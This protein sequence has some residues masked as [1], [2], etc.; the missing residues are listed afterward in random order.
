[1]DYFWS[2]YDTAV[3]LT[4]NMLNAAGTL[5]CVSGGVGFSISYL[6]ANTLNVDY[7]GE[8][9]ATGEVILSMEL[10]QLLLK[11]NETI[12][13][14][15]HV[16]RN[17][18]ATF[19]LSDYLHP[20]TIRLICGGLIASG[21]VLRLLGEN[22]KLWN[23]GRIDKS[24]FTDIDSPSIREYSLVSAKSIFGSISYTSLSSLI[25]GAVI[26]SN[27]I[28]LKSITYPARGNLHALSEYY[29]GPVNNFSIPIDYD[30]SRNVTFK[31]SDIDVLTTISAEIVAR[32]NGTYGGGLNLKPPKDGVNAPTVIPGIIGVG[33]LVACSIFNQKAIKFRDER[34]HG[35]VADD[36]SHVY[37][38]IQNNT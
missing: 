27:T 4:A 35:L 36:E 24:R 15:E 18:E 32:F 23:Q 16:E 34:I 10:L 30:F 19:H 38:Q 21:T 28:D 25:T 20:A 12:P 11:M 31:W 26:N 14:Q 1:M 3:D 22:I 29:T 8:T 17:G 13:F 2:A 6:S 5:A 7:F 33:A 9:D 37:G